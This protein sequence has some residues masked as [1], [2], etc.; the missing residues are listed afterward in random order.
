MNSTLI[1]EGPEVSY[2]TYINWINKV[3]EKNKDNK[4]FYQYLSNYNDQIDEIEIYYMDYYSMVL[5][6][7]ISIDNIKH[8]YLIPEN[9]LDL[10]I[11]A[12][13]TIVRHYEKVHIDH[14]EGLYQLHTKKLFQNLLDGNTIEN[15]ITRFSNKFTLGKDMFITLFDIDAAKKKD[16]RSEINIPTN[17]YLTP[18][19][20]KYLEKNKN[21]ENQFRYNYILK[22]Q[23]EYEN[24]N[25]P[26]KK[27]NLIDDI[28]MFI[29][30]SSKQGYKCLDIYKTISGKKFVLN[31]ESI[32]SLFK[33]YAIRAKEFSTEKYK[34][35][36]R[37]LDADKDDLSETA[38]SSIEEL[39]LKLKEEFI[40][41]G[42]DSTVENIKE[43][44]NKMIN[45]FKEEKN[46]KFYF[47][48]LLDD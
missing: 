14:I 1:K 47:V 38:V 45:S 40:K 28:I 6:G 7:I 15:L 10:A 11:Q 39:N 30:N 27:S 48:D 8:I 46:E 13:V 21:L 31:Q 18:N 3:F 35:V 44:S 19:E 33:K 12:L 42:E 43:K 41:Q 25:D 24:T 34:E 20:N 23:V 16:F 5:N 32:V 36:L 29:I 4:D 2:D 17:L 22:L 37:I 9:K 26:I